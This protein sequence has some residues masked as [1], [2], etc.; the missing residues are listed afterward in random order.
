MIMGLITLCNNT[1]QGILRLPA[2]NHIPEVQAT[3]AAFTAGVS[4]ILE[5]NLIGIYLFGSLVV[6]DFNANSS[7]INL[8]FRDP[9]H[10][11]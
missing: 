10:I 11:I 2:Q 6:G 5:D 3:L 7:D 1:S 9:N 8:T 4:S